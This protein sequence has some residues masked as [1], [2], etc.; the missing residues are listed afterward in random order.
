MDAA[1][2]VI[3]KM[4][5]NRKT[6]IIEFLGKG[7]RQPCEPADRHPNRHILAPLFARLHQ[8]A[9]KSVRIH[10]PPQK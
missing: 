4:Q 7:I 6:Q 3:R 5:S 10:K 9:T 8:T 1:E 2:V